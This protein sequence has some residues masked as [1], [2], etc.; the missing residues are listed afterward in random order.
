MTPITGWMAMDWT[1]RNFVGWVDPLEDESAAEVLI[2]PAD[3]PDRST[4]RQWKDVDNSPGVIG[5]RLGRL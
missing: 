5:S 3:S 1:V 2:L 4:T